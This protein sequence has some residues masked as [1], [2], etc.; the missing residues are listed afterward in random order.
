MNNGSDEE[1]PGN[2]SKLT[3]SFGTNHTK[4]TLS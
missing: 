3:D 1:D 4:K 2:K